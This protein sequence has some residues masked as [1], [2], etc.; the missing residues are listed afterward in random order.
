[1]FT[2]DFVTQSFPGCD[3][4]DCNRTCGLPA[5]HIREGVERTEFTDTGFLCYPVSMSCDIHAGA[6][7]H[8]DQIRDD[9]VWMVDSRLHWEKEAS[10]RPETTSSIVASAMDAERLETGYDAP[11]MSWLPP[12]SRLAWAVQRLKTATQINHTWHSIETEDCIDY[13][14]LAES[15]AKIHCDCMVEDGNGVPKWRKEQEA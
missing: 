12:H 1:M 15:W 3:T 14:A 4:S 5:T 13:E 10:F 9:T 7:R 8:P 11:D 6:I 2:C